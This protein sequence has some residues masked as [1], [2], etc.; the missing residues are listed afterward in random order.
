MKWSSLEA[1]LT[2]LKASVDKISE[3]SV[4][5]SDVTSA[6]AGMKIITDTGVL[7]GEMTDKIDELIGRKIWLIQQ[8][9][10][11]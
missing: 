1:N 10:T 2:E 11:P 7:A 3:N 4:S 9:V 6:F 5:I 8:G